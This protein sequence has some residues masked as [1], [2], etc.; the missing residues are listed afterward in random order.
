MSTEET[1]PRQADART[2][3]AIAH[4]T[5]TRILGELEASGP[6]R[7]AD[8]ARLVGIPANQASFHLRQLAKYGVVELAPELARDGRDRV[9]RLIGDRLT[10]DVAAIEKAPGG[11]AAAKVWR[12]QASAATHELV[13]RAYHGTKPEGTYGSIMDATVRLTK[14][15]ARQLAMELDQLAARWAE[16]SRGADG[17]A[18]TYVLF[19]MVQPY[20]DPLENPRAGG[21]ADS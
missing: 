16:R 18:R 3:R 9:W 5:R 17:D 13:D 8:V 21:A 7:A 10:V 4:P 14:D 15:E 12:R 6:L 1:G 2:L 19:S 11:A 20:P